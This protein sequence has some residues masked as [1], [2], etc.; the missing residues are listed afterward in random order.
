MGENEL[1]KQS[2]DKLWDE[3]ESLPLKNEGLNKN[4]FFLKIL[5]F[6]YL[7]N[8]QDELKNEKSSNPE[9]I[10]S[11][12]GFYI[13]PEYSWNNLLKEGAAEKLETLDLA[14]TFKKTNN[15]FENIFKNMHF[16]ELNLYKNVM[17]KSELIYKILK[18]IDTTV[19]Q[20]PEN[21]D[22]FGKFIENIIYKCIYANNRLGTVFY[23][24]SSISRMVSKLVSKDIKNDSVDIYDPTM[25]T[26]SLLLDVG[27]EVSNKLPNSTINYWGQDINSN[28]Y[29]ISYMNFN[30][31]D[32]SQNNI[33]L[34]NEDSLDSNVLKVNNSVKKF[35]I[36][37]EDPPY[38]LR[39]D[40]NSKRLEDERFKQYGEL[41][42]K[43]KADY[44]FVLQGLYPLKENGVM[45]IVLPNGVL[46]R[47][48]KEGKIRQ[49]LVDDNQIDTIIGLPGNMLSS[50]SIPVMV[51]ILKKNR[52]NKDILFID[53]SNDYQK[54][55]SAN[56]FR[57]QDIKKITDTYVQ[58]K[59][60]QKYS[61]IA[62]LDEIKNNDY[63]LNISRYVD[64]FNEGPAI[65]IELSKKKSLEY[66]KELHDIQSK[67]DYWLDTLEKLNTK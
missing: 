16:E 40:N 44:A 58:R 36:V 18:M 33:H 64:T 21:S 55:K 35:D 43:T 48:A 8:K 32:N 61:H 47:G 60:I 1:I 13:M 14:K 3:M 39:W 51:M 24:P 30:M 53:A 31:H 9:E 17:S 34:K 4:M 59:E 57:D 45:A 22:S 15:T 62:T 23:T 56:K 2:V 41:A 38:S 37:V 65:N 12:L 54:S 63:N 42:P 50:T 28:A 52:K 25:G 7:S 26:S 20:I 5:F 29:E 49:K 46:F 66:D 10:F 6:R 67:L 11:E 19:N 27:K